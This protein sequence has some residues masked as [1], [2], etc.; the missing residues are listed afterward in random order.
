MRKPL[1]IAL[2][3][4]ALL[5]LA[6][7]WYHK[8]CQRPA[9]PPCCPPAATLPPGGALAPAPAFPAPPGG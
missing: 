5:P 6:G 8:C 9:P 4:I 1:W 7:C 2:V 3:A